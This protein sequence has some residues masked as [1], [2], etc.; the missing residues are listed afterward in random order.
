MA[1]LNT[2]SSLAAKNFR[3]HLK[4]D[5]LLRPVHKFME[6]EA[7]GGIALLLAT[8]CALF[9][10]NTSLSTS[11]VKF[12]QQTLSLS[13]G[14]STIEMNLLHLVNDGL[15][16]LFFFVVG[17]EIKY[18]L[19]L[20]ELRS[21]KKAFLPIVAAVGGMLAPALIY[22]LVEGRGV[23]VRGWAIPMATDIAFV[24]GFLSLL[25]KR[26]PHSLK[27]TLL[28]LAIADDI[29][30]IFVIALVY[31]KSIVMDY[32][33]LSLGF[34]AVVFILNYLGVRRVL[35]YVVVG[36][37]MWYFLWRSGIHPTIAGVLL[38]LAAPATRLVTAD[39][40]TS[41]LRRFEEKLRQDP[42]HADRSSLRAVGYEM[43][44]PLERLSADLHPWVAFLIVP[45]FALANAGVP[46]QM[47]ALES[48]TAWAVIL[49]LLIGKP[50]GIY[51][52]SWVAQAFRWVSLPAGVSMRV[53]FAASCL[54][55]IGFTM[56][57][58][59][60]NLALESELLQAAK[61]GTL[62]GSALSAGLGLYLLHRFLDRRELM[63]GDELGDEKARA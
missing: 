15:M 22:L 49:G 41:Y 24:V 63:E 5:R 25:G 23:A 30:A 40:L 19:R 37:F 58:F 7:S 44:S 31:S 54:G 39:N 45:L 46:V 6:I 55:G 34:Y 52:V 56:S 29:G 38:G 21:V 42:D 8:L 43:N 14:E 36:A 35:P 28:T 16:T 51:C 32:L 33:A 1:D 59:T 60:A 20:G 50:L 62:L 12:W 18:E 48:R 61:V 4:V 2:D 47:V 9:F 17:L 57:I 26:V 3:P 10:A 13:L 11:Y 27:I 53:F